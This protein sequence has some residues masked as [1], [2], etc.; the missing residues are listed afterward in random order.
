MGPL[1]LVR[2][3]SGRKERELKKEIQEV[4]PHLHNRLDSLTKQVTL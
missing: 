2:G 1:I 3:L 4:S